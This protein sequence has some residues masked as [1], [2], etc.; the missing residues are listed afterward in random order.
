MGIELPKFG[1]TVLRF[2]GSTHSENMF[3]CWRALGH[4]P[5]KPRKK[6]EQEIAEQI[7]K[8]YELG[9]TNRELREKYELAKSTN[10]CI[11]KRRT[12]K[13]SERNKL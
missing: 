9:A 4:I 12:W 6:I 10:S 11:V 1:S 13:T 7:R 5:M 2:Y 3:H 8:E